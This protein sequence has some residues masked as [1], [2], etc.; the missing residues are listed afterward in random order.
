M[1]QENRLVVT[2]LDITVIK[3]ETAQLGKPM[4]NT[5]RIYE[6]IFNSEEPATLNAIKTALDMKPGICSGS[7][8]SLLK[9]GQIER[10]QLTAEKGR[11][12]IWGYVAKSQQKGVESSVE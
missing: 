2:V 12:N 8:A 6:V 9:S 3:G 1:S 4:K 5:T 11:K 10:V 7:L